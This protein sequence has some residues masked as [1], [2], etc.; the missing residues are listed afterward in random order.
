ME[1]DPTLSVL[2]TLLWFPTAHLLHFKVVAMDYQDN[3]C[4]ASLGDFL[5]IVG[6]YQWYGVCCVK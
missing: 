2:R 5:G 6:W 1:T 3:L 4:V